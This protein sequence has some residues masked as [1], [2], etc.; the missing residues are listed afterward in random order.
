ME[1]GICFAPSFRWDEVCVEHHRVCVKCSIGMRLARLHTVNQELVIPCPFCRREPQAGLKRH[2]HSLY[3]EKFIMR[4]IP[5]MSF[6]EYVYMLLCMMPVFCCLYVAAC[7]FGYFA[8][9]AYMKIRYV[10]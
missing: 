7:Y 2:S 8:F 1:C 10:Q 4:E 5:E 9:L 3:A 6:F